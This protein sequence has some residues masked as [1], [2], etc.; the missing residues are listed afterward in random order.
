VRPF[1]Q[2]A[3]KLLGCLL[4]TS[5][6]HQDIQDVVVLIDGSPP[7]K[8]LAV[9]GQKYLVEMPLVPGPRPPAPQLI[10]IVLPELAAPLA[11]G[12]M[13]DVDTVFTQQF[14]HVAVAPGES[15]GEPDAVADNLA[16]KAV[17]FVAL[18]GGGRGHGWLPIGVFSWF[19][20]DHYRSDYVTRQDGGST[21]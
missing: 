12:F 17:I 6:L 11:D 4:G 1:E 14:L 15:I 9:D 10:D 2:L 19:L 21:T 20:R 16:W 13:G 18:G 7:V 3:K 8:P 5:A